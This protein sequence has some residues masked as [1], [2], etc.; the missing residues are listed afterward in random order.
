MPEPGQG[1]QG[2]VVSPQVRLQHL[3]DGQPDPLALPATVAEF[4]GSDDRGAWRL[5]VPGLPANGQLV[6]RAVPPQGWYLEGVFGF[7]TP[8]AAWAS[9]P[10]AGV[11]GPVVSGTPA[12]SRVWW[13]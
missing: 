9:W 1:G 8:P 11:A 7:A 5:L 4:D 12:P 6:V 13:E 10:R 2:S 3:R